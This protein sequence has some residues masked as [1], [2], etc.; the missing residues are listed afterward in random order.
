MEA[1]ASGGELARFALALK[2]ALA[3]AKAPSR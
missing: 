3:G 2:A 1:I